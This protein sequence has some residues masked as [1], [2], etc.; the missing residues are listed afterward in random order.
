[1]ALAFNAMF[2]FAQLSDKKGFRTD[3]FLPFHLAYRMQN[4]LGM[5]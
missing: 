4:K 1:M 5:V 2:F 3:T